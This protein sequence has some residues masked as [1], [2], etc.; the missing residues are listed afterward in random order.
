MSISVVA[1][2]LVLPT[3]LVGIAEN[4]PYPRIDIASECDECHEWVDTW[5]SV[6]EAC[7]CCHDAG[8]MTN[9]Q[10]ADQV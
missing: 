4:V 9:C 1:R 8:R 5:C 3:S 6:C 2:C 7:K 10:P